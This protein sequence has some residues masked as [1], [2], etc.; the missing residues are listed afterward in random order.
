MS[1]KYR[2]KLL[3]PRLSFVTV[4]R[5]PRETLLVTGKQEAARKIFASC[6]PGIFRDC[7]PGIQDYF[8]DRVENGVAETKPL[9]PTVKYAAR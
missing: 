1:K 5:N 9:L 2:D 3:R 7:S 4:A 6:Q 8:T